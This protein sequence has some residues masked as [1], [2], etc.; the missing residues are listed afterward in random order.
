MGIEHTLESI[1]QYFLGIDFTDTIVVSKKYVEW[2]S[3]IQ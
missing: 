1:K 3:V 2:V